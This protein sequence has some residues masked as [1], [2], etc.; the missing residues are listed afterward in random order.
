M[1]DHRIP[2][3]ALMKQS[4]GA[5]R[6]EVPV[7]T[8][9]LAVGL[10]RMFLFLAFST[11]FLTRAQC[12]D[13]VDVLQ[14]ISCSGAD[15]GVLSVALP[16]GVGSEDVY[17]LQDNDTLFGAVQ[18][19]LG[20]G[21][22]LVFIPGCSALGATLNEPFPFF[23]SAAVTRL[24]TCDDPCSGEITV[25]PNFGQGD[26][27]YSWSHDA[28][29]T[30]PIG[31]DVCE[32]VVLVSAT[33]ASGC[34]DQD[35][36][37]VEIPDVEVLTFPTDPSCFGFADGSVAA[38]ATGG[39]GGG[40]TFVWEDDQGNIV[41]NAADISG[42]EAGGYLVTATDT[43]GCAQSATAFLEAPAPVDVA[44]GS[45]GISCFGEED[46][47]ASA[48]FADAALFEWSGPGGFAQ[49]G[50]DLDTLTNLA[51]GTYDVLVTASD[52]CVGAGSVEVE[53]PDLLE[54]EAFLD[55]PSCPGFVDG[56]V[57]AVP[58]GG[59]PEFTTTWTLDDG[60]TLTGDFLSGVPAGS[61]AFSTV[62]AN[63]CQASGTAELVDPDPLTVNLVVEDPLCAAGPLS[64]SGSLE[65]VPSGGLA[66]YNAAW[67][68][69]ETEQVV[70]L[71]LTAT[72]LPAGLYGLGITDASGCLLD[73]LVALVSPDSLLLNITA[74]D[75]LCAGEETGS[76]SAEATGGTPEY[77]YLWTGDVAPTISASV[78]GLGPGSYAVEVTDGQGCQAVSEV[79]LTAPEPVELTLEAV[80]VGCAGDDG[81]AT[82]SAVGGT[83]PFAFTW[84]DGGGAPAG[85]G[86]TINGLSPGT[87]AVGAMDDNGCSAAATV[88]V[89]TLPPV[90]LDAEVSV[91]D[92]ATGNALLTA[93]AT[94]GE[95]PVELQLDG[96][97]GMVD[98]ADW[99]ALPPGA[100]V[101]T[102][103]DV[104]GCTDSLAF[105]VDP[106]ITLVTEV[107][108]FGCG[109][110]GSVTVDVTGGDP[111]AALV[112]S[113]AELGPPTMASANSATWE[114]LAAGSYTI[115][116]GDGTCTVEET[117]EMTGVTLFDWTV[118]VADYAC[119]AAPG[120]ISIAVDGG[121]EPV[122]STG[123]S[124]DGSVTWSTLVNDTLSPGTYTLSVT[125]A[126]GC[127]RDTTVEV[128]SLPAL[129]LEVTASDISCFGAD[130]GTIEVVTGGGSEPITVG[131]DGPEGLVLPPFTAMTAGVYQVGVVDDRGCTADTTVEVLEPAPID[132]ESSVTPESCA[133]TSD[134]AVVVTASGGTGNLNVQWDGGPGEEGW[135]GL[136]SGTYTWSV[137]DE[138][139]CDT[140]GTLEVLN[141]G[142]LTAEAVVLPAACED[143][144]PEGAVQV[145]LQGSAP[146]A[147]VLLG[148][149][150]ADDQDITDSTGTWTWSDLAAGTYGWSA[151]VGEGCSASGQV[152]VDLPDP[153]VFAASVTLPSCSGETGS[154]ESIPYG[155]IQ[156]LYLHWSGLT[157][158]GDTLQGEGLAADLPEG[159]YTWS[160]TDNGGCTADTTIEI[161]ALSE[162]PTLTQELTQPSC[163]G[164]LVGSAILTPSG[165]ISPYDIVVQGAADTTDLPFLIPGAYPL[166]LTDSAGCAF[167]DT[168]LIETAS[169]FELMAEVV[170]A[171]CF[172]SEDGEVYFSTENG[173][174]PVEYTFVGPFGAQAV[175]D[176]VAGL[177]AGVYEV[178]AIDSA[179]CP[180]VL[181]VEVGSPPP[182]VVV[183]DSLLR[184]SCAGDFDGY[185]AVSATGGSG[186]PSTFIFQ[187]TLD[188][189]GFEDGPDIAGLGE[190]QYAVVAVDSAGCTGSIASIPLVAQGDVSLVVPADT[191]LCAGQPLVLE[192]L[193]EGAT[194]ASWS[195]VDGTGGP[196]L[197]GS[198]P[199]VTE[200]DGQWV[201]TATRLGC[202]RSDTVQVVG[203]ALPVP[204]AG[205]DQLIA[206]GATAAL[207]ATDAP[208]DWSYQWYP[209]GD[210]AFPESAT[211]PTEPLEQTTT[212]L[213][214]ATTAEGCQATDTVVIEVLGTLDIPS[215]FT[216]NDD[217]M[218]DRWNLGGLEQYPSAEITVFN[219]W[220]NVLFTRGINDPAWDGTINGIPV[221]VGTYYYHIRVDEP[222]MQAEWTG[223]ITI[224]R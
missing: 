29:E 129:S 93:S 101:L 110:A 115:A 88:E 77:N 73:T 32:Q 108:P 76:V 195:I 168:I 19:G 9:W 174:G 102:A 154:V 199:S 146:S 147:T 107:I 21:S 150:P 68:D 141:A 111:E 39:L 169:D 66:P 91:V 128:G 56:V 51:P 82:V 1:P 181:L 109:S 155:G 41:G 210:V 26:I 157:T 202:V 215:G 194:E 161:A 96:P 126:V 120:S 217:G 136:G 148:G 59:T 25:T 203:W 207:G 74:A 137:S 139:G 188:G 180:S 78:E 184:P 58:F 218:N 106:A 132:V 173:Q 206:S 37:T 55:P 10:S 211:T 44:M 97:G 87:Y 127:Q 71:G 143:G 80:P 14:P 130:D 145:V 17:W 30:G 193:A 152:E 62:D 49:S 189:A 89:T 28:A 163:G 43:G 213:L 222:A 64:A 221:P 7:F 65:A 105:T 223:P 46:G 11:P 176:T 2:S 52:G 99:S 100:Y 224:M 98:A 27:T 121:T 119:Q 3:I 53:S 162:G 125:D 160:L 42:L 205:E 4:G 214:E 178:T 200:G 75:P 69:A 118:S 79:E 18:A 113:S 135:S 60:T 50:A 138:N 85:T 47:Q 23:I 159:T 35:I 196:G 201:F 165:G 171:A 104:R 183:L 149:L 219:R 67:V 156:P 122:E 142:S 92:C 175:G 209:E 170:P 40:F 140:T 20:P 48:S 12:P 31:T 38:V 198:T 190:G 191:A 24:P 204:D 72:E 63:G 151:E 86:E 45:E 6:S 114:D 166:V 36:I 182:L 13:E 33:D 179:G 16:D 134:G 187:W 84:T 57:G 177:G 167:H 112:F 144:V 172:N 54:V 164:A 5:Y 220:G 95:E 123:S 208:S 34:S 81:E 197:S 216:P 185:L 133:G 116:V 131:A 83:A 158:S 124:A 90:A 8:G 186:D 94:G 22:Y 61:Y 153:L 15:D 70:A 103:S 117:V 212:F 192:A